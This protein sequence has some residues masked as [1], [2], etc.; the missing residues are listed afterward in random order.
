LFRQGSGAEAERLASP[1]RLAHSSFV[2]ACICGE[3]E[4]ACSV[5][6]L[7][8]AP[9]HI[10][11]GTR[12]GPHLVARLFS[13]SHIHTSCQQTH[14][15]MH[16]AR[17][18]RTPKYSP[19]LLRAKNARICY[20]RPLSLSFQLSLS[21]S[22]FLFLSLSLF[23]FFSLSLYLSLASLDALGATHLH[24]PTRTYT[25]LHLQLQ[26][27][28]TAAHRSSPQSPAGLKE[29]LQG[30]KELLQ[31]PRSSCYVF[32]CCFFS[33]RTTTQLPTRKERERA[34][35]KSL[36]KKKGPRWRKQHRCRSWRPLGC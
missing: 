21:F 29:L 15:S 32:L 19:S 22:L 9:E 24:A 25:H 5:T 18:V 3:A 35:K 31:A 2:F 23:F 7:G 13:T 14:V 17:G 6:G 30:L 20:A 12:K 8:L 26:P 1:L 10:L 11:D 4:G 27:L 33:L 36:Q 28:L 16:T 34:V